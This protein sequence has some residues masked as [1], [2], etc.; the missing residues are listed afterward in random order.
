MAK[1]EIKSGRVAVNGINYHYEIHSRGEPLL[2][3]HGGLG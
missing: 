1:I 2:L 3:L